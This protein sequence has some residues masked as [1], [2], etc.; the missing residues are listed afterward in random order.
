MSEVTEL[1]R[2]L[3]R[4]DSVNLDLSREPLARRCWPSRREER[5]R[6]LDHPAS[7]LFSPLD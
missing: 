7:G 6:R 2:A 5:T 3:I 4:I 1:A